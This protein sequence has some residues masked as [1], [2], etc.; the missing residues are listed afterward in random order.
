M[1]PT[2]LADRHSTLAAR[3]FVH[4]ALGDNGVMT[5]FDGIASHLSGRFQPLLATN[6]PTKAADRAVTLSSA[7]ATQFGLKFNDSTLVATNHRKLTEGIRWT[8]ATLDKFTGTRT[9]TWAMKSER[10]EAEVLGLLS[11]AAATHPITPYDDV[12]AQFRP[13]V[14]KL[15]GR[16]KFRSAVACEAAL[17]GYATDIGFAQGSP[18]R[19]SGP[20]MTWNCYWPSK[21]CRVI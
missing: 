19:W 3:P 5:F 1:R 20:P 7:I 17:V 21:R 9:E 13:G 10:T 16:G 6:A 2:R 15:L 14:N 4:L 11:Q 12:K 18:G 8:Y